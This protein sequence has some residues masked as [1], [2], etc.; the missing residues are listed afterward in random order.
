M[1]FDSIMSIKFLNINRYSFTLEV[2][3][4]KSHSSASCNVTIQ[5][6]QIPAISIV[7][8]KN[9]PEKIHP[10]K[11]FTVRGNFVNSTFILC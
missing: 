6:G 2:T 8:K 4:G 7:R 3:N 1:A 5:L 11:Q 10:F 9:A